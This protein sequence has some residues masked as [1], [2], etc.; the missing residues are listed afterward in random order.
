MSATP[1]GT[2]SP[3]SAMPGISRRG[4]QL[5]IGLFRVELPGE[6]MLAAA[7]ADEQNS[8][9]GNIGARAARAVIGWASV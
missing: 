8:H 9:G 3:S 1:I 4:D 5:E 7:A 6:R 2:H